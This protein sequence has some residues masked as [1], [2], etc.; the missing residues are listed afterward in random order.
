MPKVQF[1][2]MMMMMMM[3]REKVQGTEARSPPAY[4]LKHL[5]SRRESASAAG[6]HAIAVK[7]PRVS[8]FLCVPVPEA[9]AGQ[10]KKKQRGG[11]AKRKG[12]PEGQPTLQAQKQKKQKKG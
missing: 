1:Q 2:L 3:K 5:T 10:G 8:P 7:L 9:G 4:N 12:G 11:K 6:A